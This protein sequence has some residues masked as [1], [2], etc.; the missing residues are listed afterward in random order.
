MRVVSIGIPITKAN[1]DNHSLANAPALFDYDACVVDMR[2]VSEQIEAMAQGTR[3]FRTPDEREVQAGGSG[4]FHFGLGEL[5]E[6]RREELRR[7]VERGG[8][9]V[10]LAY[11][12]VPHASVTTL[13]GLDRYY[14]L[15]APA[16][17]VYRPPF[18]KPGSGQQISTSDGR[19]AAAFMVRARARLGQLTDR[20]TGGGGGVPRIF[21]S[22]HFPRTT[23]EVRW[24]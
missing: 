1:V 12:N 16:E 7:L 9:V 20:H 4:A 10:A 11:P 8:T 14:L 3:E 21:S 6:L 22:N 19:H 2:A 15:P 13:P 5:L 23:G 18:L 17:V 24:A